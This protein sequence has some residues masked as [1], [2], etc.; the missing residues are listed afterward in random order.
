MEKLAQRGRFQKLHAG[1]TPFES[2]AQKAKLL[3]QGMRQ[4]FR[5]ASGK[6]KA[7]QSD[8]HS[9]FLV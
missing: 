2:S 3:K 6:F 5:I 7:F 9:S 4:P 8:Q 1:S